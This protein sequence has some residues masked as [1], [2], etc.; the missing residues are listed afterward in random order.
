MAAPV[1][2][3]S[4]LPQ[5]GHREPLPRE[6]ARTCQNGPQLRGAAGRSV[7]RHRRGVIVADR[8]DRSG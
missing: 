6:T 4:G 1:R 5:Y 7:E 3:H 2:V 8:N